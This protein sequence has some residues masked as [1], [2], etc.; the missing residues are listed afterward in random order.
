MVAERAM[1]QIAVWAET[2]RA[3]RR[4]RIALSRRARQNLQQRVDQ[5]LAKIS[6]KAKP[7]SHT[8]K[9][10]TLEEA[11]A[12]CDEGDEFQRLRP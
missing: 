12:I 1:V 6:V 7:A 4:R 11:S 9:A 8:A 10:R 5:I 2:A 3:S